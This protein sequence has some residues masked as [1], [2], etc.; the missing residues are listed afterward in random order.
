MKAFIGILTSRA[1][2]RV[3]S[4]ANTPERA[5][6]VGASRVSVAVVGV[7]GAFVDVRATNTVT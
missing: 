6:V 1:G 4:V 7:L 3:A 2:A 5:R